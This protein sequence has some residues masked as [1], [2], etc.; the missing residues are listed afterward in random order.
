MHIDSVSVQQLLK[1][2]TFCPHTCLKIPT[3]LV[4]CTVIDA[5][6]RIAPNIQ[7]A[8]FHFVSV[9]PPALCLMGLTPNKSKCLIS[10]PQKRS[11]LVRTLHQNMRQ[12]AI[13]GKDIEFGDTIVHLGHVIRSDMD[14]IGDTENQRC[15]C[16]GQTNN[17]L[18]YFGKLVSDV[19]Y[20][21]FRS[22]C[23]S[24]CGSVLWY[25][26]NKRVNKLCTEWR[27]RLRRIW[28]L[29]YDAHCDVACY[30]SVWWYVNSG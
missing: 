10:E 6:V 21:L 11:Q 29:P 4:N 27:K 18:C 24:M 8:L 9:M 23:S 2:Y 25:A 12:F 22:Y 19:K 20:R 16:I 3:P 30:W 28:N 5:L 14:D 17:V 15:K 1:V 13:G 26:G 7:R